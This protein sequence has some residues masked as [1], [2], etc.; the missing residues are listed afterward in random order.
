MSA[1]IEKLLNRVKKMLALANDS[2]ASEGERDN[3]LRMAHATLAKHNLSMQ[4]VD[5][6][7]NSTSND[8][9]LKQEFDHEADKL[10]GRNTVHGIGKLFFCFYFSYSGSNPRHC[11]VGKSVNVATATYMSEYVIGSIRRESEQAVKRYYGDVKLN[12]ILD[13][14]GDKRPEASK[15]V[16]AEAFCAEAAKVVHERCEQMARDAAN[17][18]A[19]GG[20]GN[21]VVLASVYK[22]EL[23]ANRLFLSSLGIQLQAGR[24]AGYQRD[25][26]SARSAGQAFGKSINLSQ[27]IGNSSATRRLK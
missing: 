21:S 24:S 12:S 16:W 8:P 18:R 6:L 20:N 7:G 4:E 19:E 10:W 22:N 17:Q 11:L 2:A 5:A 26:G 1:E 3:A 15:P 9:R 13:F 23:E 14:D 25:V 27:Q